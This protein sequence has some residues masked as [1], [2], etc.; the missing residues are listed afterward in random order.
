LDASKT[1]DGSKVEDQKEMEG[2]FKEYGRARKNFEQ[3]QSF[4]LLAQIDELD[5]EQPPT[6]DSKIWMTDDVNGE[7][8][9][10]L[11]HHGRALARRAVDAERARRFEVKTLWVTKFWLPLLAALVGIIGALTGLVAVLQHKK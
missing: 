11:T 3:E 10:L 1:L 7:R 9:I 4:A 2:L 6:S 8:V 5:L